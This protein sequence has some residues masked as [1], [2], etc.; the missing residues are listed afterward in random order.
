[1]GVGVTKEAR[2]WISKNRI[3]KILIIAWTQCKI[4]KEIKEKRLEK[5]KIITA[6]MQL[7]TFSNIWV[8]DLKIAA[9]DCWVENTLYGNCVYPHFSIYSPRVALIRYLV[10]KN[11]CNSSISSG[12]IL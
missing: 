9:Q 1:M 5:T 2:G 4:S 11:T 7:W 8:A 6:T 3:E 12:L 10:D